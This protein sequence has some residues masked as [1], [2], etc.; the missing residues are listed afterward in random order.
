MKTNKS[1]YLLPK[2]WQVRC[3]ATTSKQ[4]Y[5]ETNKRTAKHK[6][7]DASKSNNN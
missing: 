4:L 5:M 1:T 3:V 2:E 6:A 7:I